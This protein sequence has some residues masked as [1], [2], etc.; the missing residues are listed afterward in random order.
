MGGPDKIIR[1][2]VAAVLVILYT[3]GTITGSLG[4]IAL[5]LA[6]I[7]IV[8]SLISFCPLYTLFGIST[9]KKSKT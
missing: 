4:W 3:N 2:L 9:C 7:F 8:T 6:G 1:L 5:A